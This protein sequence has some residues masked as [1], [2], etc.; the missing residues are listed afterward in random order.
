MNYL[1]KFNALCRMIKIEHSIFALPFAWLGLF[2][3]SRGWPDWRSFILLSLAMVSGRSFA[4]T[5][6]RIADLR[7]DAANPRTANRPLVTGEIS[8]AQ[9]RVFAWS[10]AAL[11]LLF[12]A[13][14]N[15]GC[16]WLGVLILLL[17]LL[18]SYAKRFTWLC[19][20]ILGAVLGLSPLAG[21][22][23]GGGIFTAAP[24][25]FPAAG[26]LTPV[27]LTDLSGSISM[28]LV[29]LAVMFWVAGFDIIYAC[30]DIDFDQRNRLF[31]MPA[32]L[33]LDRALGLAAAFHANTV[34]FLLLGGWFSGLGFL[35][36]VVLAIV[37]ALLF[38]QHRMVSP[39]D[40]S[41]VNAAFFTLNAAV[42]PLIFLGLVLSL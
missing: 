18:Y 16:F 38:R 40:L 39:S 30:Q 2:S 41:R 4:M 12:S 6:N 31:S 42:S 11:L 22:L 7:Y 35:W 33:G 32:H 37:A 3:A 14:L 26:M 27:A 13:L 34:L 19:H 8:P 9:A 29:G 23:A 36:Y 21:W 15:A 10:A 5:M 1:Q 24:P 17:S 28:V 20:F 25:V